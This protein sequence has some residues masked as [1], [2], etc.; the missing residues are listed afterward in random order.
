MRR[1]R[2]RSVA[3]PRAT[4]R[5]LRLR[6]RGYWTAR[7]RLSWAVGAAASEKARKSDA[8][9]PADGTPRPL[10]DYPAAVQEG[11]SEHRLRALFEAS[12]ALT[13]EL[14]LDAL[15]QKLAETA[16]ALTGARFAALGVIDESGNALERFLTTGIDPA[17]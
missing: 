17:T 13:S 7:T 2:S 8:E 3:P 4:T 10:R 14:S 6:L 12:I 16:A 11:Q 1:G 5:G 15:L 9:L